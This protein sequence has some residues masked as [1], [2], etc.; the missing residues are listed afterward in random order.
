[1][2]ITVMSSGLI[3]GEKMDDCKATVSPRNKR[4]HDISQAL[5]RPIACPPRPPVRAPVGP[6][7]QRGRPA[8]DLRLPVKEHLSGQGD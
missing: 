6:P 5:A 1:M 3:Y 8:Q 7:S 4:H 2:Q